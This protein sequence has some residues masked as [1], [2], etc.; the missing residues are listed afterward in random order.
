MRKIFII[1]CASLAAIAA[2]AQT[3]IQVQVP[4]VVTL[5]EQFNITFVIE[6]ARPSSFDW[7]PGDDIQNLWGPQEGR[8][9]SVSIVNGKRTESSQTIYSYMVQAN[10]AGKITI[11]KAKAIVNG[12]EIVSSSKVIEV[13]DSASSNDNGAAGQSG[14]G[15]SSSS[16][17]ISATDMILVVD[18]SKRNVVV[19]EP[20]KATVKF[21][22]KVGVSS[23]EQVTYPD[24]DGFV[25]Q[26]TV[27]PSLFTFQREVL[28]GQLYQAT[29]LR[30]LVLTPKRSGTLEIFPAKMVVLRDVPV[31]SYGLYTEYETNRYRLESDP[32]RINVSSLPSPAPASFA[33]GV[34]AFSMT[35]SLSSDSL[36]VHGAAQLQLEVKGTGNIQSLEIPKIDFPSDFELYDPTVT[37][38]VSSDGISGVRVYQYPFMPRKVGQYEVGPIQYTYYDT[39]Q[40]KY[41]TIDAGSLSL[42]VTPGKTDSTTVSSGAVSYKRRVDNRNTDI[43]GIAVKDPNLVEKGEFFMG[44]TLFWVLVIGLILLAWIL[45]LLLGHI[46]ARR[47]DVVG[48]KTRKATKMALKRLRVA[49]R[50]LESNQYSEFYAELHRALLGYM[51]DKMNMSMSEL[52]KDRMSEVLL[53]NGVLDVYVT[54][55]IEILDSCEYARYAPSTGNQAMVSD[56]EKA[57]EVIASIDSS[58]KTR[59]GNVLRTLAV[60][61]MVF[62]S[63]G[64]YADDMSHAESLWNEANAA[65]LEG[66]FEDAIKGYE[67]ISSMGLESAELYYNTGNAWYKAGNNAK[68]ILYYER[69]LKLDP[70]YS[71]ASYNLEI[72]NKNIQD[73]V[74]PISEFFLK[75]WF[76]SISSLMSSNAWAVMFV[77]LFAIIIALVLVFLLSASVIWRRISFFTGLVVLI[78]MIAALSFSIWQKSSYIDNDEAIVMKTETSIKNSPSSNNSTE[79]FILHEGTK[80]KVLE[81]MGAWTKIS[82]ADGRQGWMQT[83]DIERI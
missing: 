65:Y 52:S 48:A 82:I 33:G 9:S 17:D 39:A 12:N 10:K 8:S 67:S 40:R 45:W 41:V 23:F 31:A 30:E 66:N 50:L 64:L 5:D 46:R 63:F 77:V 79:L 73:K 11:P 38:D 62:S 6:G 13:F 80:V 54:N 58:M 47:D 51:S 56:Y 72:A 59:R 70:S 55:L 35:A 37:T 68:A 36:S 42:T 69:A 18:V 25:S 57:I 53:Q 29:L 27:A 76:R 16:D 2:S 20:L 75:A 61:V 71:D 49:G 43:R 34:G 60:I 24:F 28:N 7:E 26:V 4:G 3:S 32:V 78:P 83:S 44:S 19:G 14:N 1:I 22:T 15:N 81:S 21:Y 74:E